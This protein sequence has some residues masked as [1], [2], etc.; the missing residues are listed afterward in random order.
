[1]GKTLDALIGRSSKTARKLN[2]LIKL[3][4]S[5]ISILKNHQIVRCSQ[6]ESDVIE[7]L[8]LGYQERALIRVEQVIKEQNALDAI[9]LIENYC[10]LL[11]ERTEM[12]KNSRECP[13]ELKETVSTLIFAASRCGEFPE[14][15]EIRVLFTSK[16]G[17]EFAKRSVEL[18]NNC[19]VYPKM[20]QRFST[21]QPSLES[22]RNF[23][24]QIAKHNGIALQLDHEAFDNS[25]EEKCE[26]E[27]V[28][29]LVSKESNTFEACEIKAI[30][31]EDHSTKA[32]KS[33]EIS[34]SESVKAR[35]YRDAET[36]AQDAFES[37]AYAAVAARAALELSRLESLDDD[38]SD[39]HSGSH[40]QHTQYES[41][42]IS[43]TQ[44]GR[45][46]EASEEVNYLKL[47]L[48]SDFTLDK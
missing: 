10:R 25:K 20:I 16:F 17:R 13:D 47:G 15:H 4:I 34:L 27:H 8:Q 41:S 29:T 38:D 7:L 48:K 19:Q 33:C 30:T 1:M 39:D 46:E 12:V 18:R 6:A 36:A 23:L 44:A 37:A 9:V 14:L 5:R 28:H 35:N 40:H 32:A 24:K 31:E 45:G 26:D 2:M 22:R 21:Q 42:S 3:A 11:V 43:E